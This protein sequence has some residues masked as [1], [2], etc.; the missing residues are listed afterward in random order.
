MFLK[1]FGN[2]KTRSD[3]ILSTLTYL[4]IAEEGATWEEEEAAAA[5]E[6]VV[7]EEAAEE[8]AAVAEE[9]AAAMAVV[10]VSTRPGAA[11]RNSRAIKSPLIDD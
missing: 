8:D 2:F 1:R 3:V 9:A 6:A 4:F 11:L 10:E 7:E 5:A